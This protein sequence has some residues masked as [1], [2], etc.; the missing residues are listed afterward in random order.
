LKEKWFRG[1]MTRAGND[2]VADEIA[3]ALRSGR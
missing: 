1:H 2:W 3:A